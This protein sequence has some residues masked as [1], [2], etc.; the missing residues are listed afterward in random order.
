M[1]GS[2]G[3]PLP[4]DV[5]NKA[6][7]TEDKDVQLLINLL[8]VKLSLHNKDPKACP[9]LDFYP[10]AFLDKNIDFY[11]LIQVLDKTSHIC[12]DKREFLNWLTAYVNGSLEDNFTKVKILN[13]LVE[14]SVKNNLSTVLVTLVQPGLIYKFLLDLM[15]R[16]LKNPEIHKL[17][18]QTLISYFKLFDKPNKIECINAAYY[19]CR[20]INNL[21]L[22]C[23]LLNHINGEYFYTES[24]C[25][26]NDTFWILIE[27]HISGQSSHL[28]K[29]GIQILTKY[30]C[31]NTTF[32]KVKDIFMSSDTEVAWQA[33][34]LLI[35]VGRE[36]QLHLVEPSLNLFKC[37]R[38]LPLL[39]QKCCYRIFLQ[40]S[41]LTVI[42]KVAIDIFKR[43]FESQ[44]ELREML[45]LVLPA[46]NKHEYS[47]LSCEVFESLAHFCNCLSREHF[48]VVLE[49]ITAISSWNPVSFWKVIKSVLTNINDKQKY[50]SFEVIQ[51]ILVCANN[52]PHVYIRIET[53]KFIVASLWWDK[54]NQFKILETLINY[55]NNKVLVNYYF[56]P[57][58]ELDQMFFDGNYNQLDQKV[59]F[60]ILQDSGTNNWLKF[61]SNYNNLSSCLK[62][63]AWRDFLLQSARSKNT[64]SLKFNEIESFLLSYFEQNLYSDDTANMFITVFKMLFSWRPINDH[65]FMEVIRKP[66][67]NPL[68]YKPIQIYVA[69]VLVQQYL[70]K[71]QVRNANGKS[72]Y[73]YKSYQANIRV[74]FK[75]GWRGFFIYFSNMDDKTT[76]SSIRVDYSL[77]GIE[78]VNLIYKL[79]SKRTFTEEIAEKTIEQFNT[80]LDS[81]GN[82]VAHHIYA[83]TYQIFLQISESPDITKTLFNNFVTKNLFINLMQ[84]KKDQYY[85]DIATKFT[86]IVCSEN[87]IKYNKNELDL[88]F[89]TLLNISLQCP[90]IRLTFTKELN[91]VVSR[92][93]DKFY[94]KL[95]IDLYLQGVIITKDER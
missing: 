43:V 33:F 41:Q 47:L 37:I 20:A 12:N 27:N 31:V 30:V 84:L 17:A 68:T 52:L 71:Q 18:Y 93:N 8:N 1:G 14:F 3:R 55:C 85:K 51:R 59:W 4:N 78:C 89:D 86:K 38:H 9:K 6:I 83:K 19:Y 62:L 63:L 69:L 74:F 75:S 70:F 91:N 25:L 23:A 56:S 48:Q 92:N 22:I 81:Q 95:I 53:I 45:K 72:F 34:F 44:N 77:I 2:N 67:F 65:M 40:H 32:N 26:S 88:I 16:D 54:T 7:T 73:F 10:I 29:Q 58:I 76:M 15:K 50:V 87:F 57:K 79:A 24:C 80:L 66:L 42:Y 13:Y 49:E 28:Q 60:N 94:I 61:Q 82:Q 90:Q 35:D 11:L 5:L 64:L 39:W 21:D 46:I 36:K